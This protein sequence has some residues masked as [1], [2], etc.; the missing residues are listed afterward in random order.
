M[1]NELTRDRW[2][3]VLKQKA[4]SEEGPSIRR[5][6][7]RHY[8]LG[9]ATIRE[10]S[11]D[12]TP[13]DKPVGAKGELIQVSSEGCM[14]RTQRELKPMTLVEVEIPIDDDV[15]V[16]SGKVIHSTGTVGGY[17]TGIQLRFA[18]SASQE[19]GRWGSWSFKK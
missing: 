3:E 13:P 8:A 9:Y 1:P 12:D 15:Y 18:Q 7:S 17:K 10:T 2:L 11:S 4:E 16:V 5:K 14:V 19:A 6:H